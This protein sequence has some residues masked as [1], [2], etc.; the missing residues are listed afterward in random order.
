MDLREKALEIAKKYEDLSMRDKIEIIAQTFGCTSGV[1][2]TSPCY[3]RKWRG[4]SDM[5]IRFDNGLSLFLTNLRTPEAKTVGAQN[6][7]VNG[8]LLWFN[9]EIVAATKEAAL[10]ALRKRETADNMIAAEK[11]SKPYT[12]LNVELNCGTDD[13]SNGYLGWYYVTLAVGGKIHAH[14][15]TGL[16][17]EIADGKV[18][19]TPSRYR[20]FAAGGMKETDVDYVFNNVG[21]SSKS[22]HYSLPLP[23]DVLRRAEKT[24][25]ERREAREQSQSRKP[26]IKAQLAARPVPSS[27]PTKPKEKEA[28]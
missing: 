16:A 21:F 2:E 5:S 28:R 11:G 20:Y 24:L 6:E 9:P 23:D 27:Q 14:L 15:E 12:L 22:M 25:A 7:Y 1:I 10:P 19:E 13:R 26:S 18:S 17:H 8:A 3:G 4:T